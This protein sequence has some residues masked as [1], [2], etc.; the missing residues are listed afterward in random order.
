MLETISG[1][2][3]AGG[4][5]MGRVRCGV[6]PELARRQDIHGWPGALWPG[7]RTITLHSRPVLLLLLGYGGAHT[8]DGSFNAEIIRSGADSHDTAGGLITGYLTRWGNF[9]TKVKTI[10]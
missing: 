2:T 4:D 9:G 8:S 6:T 7:Y 3:A 10:S 5:P 1:S